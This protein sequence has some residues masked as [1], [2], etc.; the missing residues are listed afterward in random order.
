MASPLE[1]D[2]GVEGVVT[3]FTP[4][5]VPSIMANIKSKFSRGPKPSEAAGYSDDCAFVILRD[6]LQPKSTLSLESVVSA[7][8]DL[9][10]EDAPESSAVYSFGAL[11]L[12]MGERIP[13]HHPSHQKMALL[14]EKLGVFTKVNSKTYLG[15]K[16]P[17]YNRYQRLG[18]YVKDC[19]LPPAEEEPQT[20]VNYNAF[21]ANI[22]RCHVFE[23][24]PT[25][26][27]WA[28]RDALEKNIEDEALCIRD[29]YIIGAAQWIL[30]NGQKLFAQIKYTG[31]V[32]PQYWSPGELYSGEGLLTIHRWRFWAD[33]FRAMAGEKSECSD[34]C[35]AVAV[36][37][38]DMMD[39][40]EKYM[41]F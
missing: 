40:F 10:P 23:T 3:P 7:L 2:V 6:F 27:I 35:K 39:A 11:C 38:A 31:T 20:Y 36:K 9:L 15:G 13:Y 41:T 8:V 34:E 25:Y 33:R 12:D 14:L 1:F 22:E 32:F 30:W 26:A 21:V 16:S 18:E 37:A 5:T 17:I 4:S 29:S 28:M 19:R 24:D